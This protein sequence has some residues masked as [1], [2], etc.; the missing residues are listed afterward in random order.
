MTYHF[1]IESKDSQRFS[2]IL[3]TMG[4]TDTIQCSLGWENKRWYDY[5]MEVT[6]EELLLIKL[7]IPLDKIRLVSYK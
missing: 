6:E 1:R 5:I 7:S 2:Q 3:K 4:K